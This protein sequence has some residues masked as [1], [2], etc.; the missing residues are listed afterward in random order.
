MEGTESTTAEGA[1]ENNENQGLNQK[2]LMSNKPLHR[3]VQKEPRNIG[4]TQQSKGICSKQVC[5]NR[6]DL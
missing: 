2:V 6:S 5:G 1:T 3:F 4:V